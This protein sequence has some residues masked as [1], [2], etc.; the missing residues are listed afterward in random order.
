MGLATIAP[1]GPDGL[2]NSAHVDELMAVRARVRSNAVT[3]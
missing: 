3:A 1:T 2:F